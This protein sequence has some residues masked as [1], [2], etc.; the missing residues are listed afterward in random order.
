MKQLV[1]WVTI[2]YLRFLAKTALLIH[3]PTIIGISG[4][5][6]KTS[7]K[8]AV[9]AS[10]KDYFSTDFT[11]GNSETGVPLGILGIAQTDFS[12]LGYLKI[13]LLCPFHIFHTQKLKYLIVEMGTDEPTPP[14]NMEYL[15]T[16]IKPDIAL[17]LNAFAAHTMQ[18]EQALTANDLEAAAKDP[19]IRTYLVISKIAEEDGKIITRS[20][21]Q[22]GIYCADNKPVV[23]VIESVNNPKLKL[24]AFGKAQENDL[25]YTG[26]SVD[27]EK[28]KFNFRI[29]EQKMDL[30]LKGFALPQEYQEVFAPAILVGIQLGLNLNQIKTGLEKNFVLPKS[31]AS[32]LKGINNSI[33][34]DSSYNASKGAILIFLKLLQ[35]LKKQTKRP[36]VFVFGDMR[37]L[38]S[39]SEPEHAEVAAEIPSIVDYLYC[40]GPETQK[41]V[42]PRVKGLVGREKVKWFAS[43]AELGEYLKGSLPKHSLVLAKGSQNTIF[44][45]ETVK[46]ILA[47]QRDVLKL[48]RQ[49]PFWLK[50]KGIK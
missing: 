31:R 41:Y 43:S 34:I 28:T 18:F 8:M 39:H 48:C 9:F 10:L 45:E 24:L 17:F 11:V 14:R 25:T 19:S 47:D 37:E 5:V 44:L 3:R 12:V 13:I 7:T 32:I 20:G 15:L 6:G 49:D 23:K 26:Y 30:E 27:T 42:I 22:T 1:F 2:T 46:A 38:G 50:K 35:E 29:G 16:I 40:V 33:I 4:S 36:V 21:C